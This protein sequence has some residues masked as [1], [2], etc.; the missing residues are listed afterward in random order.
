MGLASGPDGSLYI[1]DL[2]SN[3]IRRVD[4][5]GIMTTVAGNGSSCVNTPAAPCGDGGLAK[6]SSLSP[7]S[8]AVGPDKSL[9]IVDSVSH[10]V[11]RVGP[12]GIIEKYWGQSTNSGS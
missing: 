12:N 9:Y 10:R 4:P 1:A 6:Q 3:R 2:S 8:V 5:R 7:Q 11:R